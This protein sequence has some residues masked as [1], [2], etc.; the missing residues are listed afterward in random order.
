VA[1]NSEA[2]RIAA[3]HGFFVSN[4]ILSVIGLVMLCQASIE[5]ML[6]LDF[7]KLLGISQDDARSMT[8]KMSF[9]SMCDALQSLVFSRVEKN[10]GEAEKFRNLVPRIIEQRNTA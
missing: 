6:V 5:R 10:S 1:D 2:F 8:A 7:A 9:R 3:D 4:K